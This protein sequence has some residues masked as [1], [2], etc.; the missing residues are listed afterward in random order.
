MPANKYISNYGIQ[1]FNKNAVPA[2]DLDF[3]NPMTQ[4][5]YGHTCRLFQTHFNHASVPCFTTDALTSAPTFFLLQFWYWS[6][7]DHRHSS[8]GRYSFDRHHGDDDYTV[9]QIQKEHEQSH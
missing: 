8:G 3:R 5:T 7:Y 4:D 2:A 6:W 1:M 9:R